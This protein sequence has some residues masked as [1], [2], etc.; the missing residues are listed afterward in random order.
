VIL[1]YVSNMIDMVRLIVI[2]HLLTLIIL[3]T[4]MYTPQFYLERKFLEEKY[5]CVTFIII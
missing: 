5:I 3:S 2:I 1:D 4:H